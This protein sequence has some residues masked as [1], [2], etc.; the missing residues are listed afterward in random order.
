M[1][2]RFRWYHTAYRFHCNNSNDKCVNSFKAEPNGDF[3][4]ENMQSHCK[5]HSYT[6]ESHQMNIPYLCIEKRRKRKRRNLCRQL[7]L[8][9]HQFCHKNWL[10]LKI[11]SKCAIINESLL[12]MCRVFIEAGRWTPN[13]RNYL[14]SILCNFDFT[15]FSSTGS[16]AICSFIVLKRLYCSCKPR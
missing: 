10:K 15:S 1:I 13:T 11:D 4:F 8:T 6:T 12:K 5:T 9:F 14:R 2:A 16:R 7:Q 3:T